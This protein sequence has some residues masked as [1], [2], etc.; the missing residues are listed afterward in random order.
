MARS[1]RPEVESLECEDARQPRLVVQCR[2]DSFRFME[3][4]E[5]ALEFAERR[6]RSPQAEPQVKPLLHDCVALREARNSCQRLSKP[7]YGLAMSGLCGGL[8]SCL[9]GVR[10][11]LIPDL[12]AHCVVRKPFDVLGNPVPIEAFGR[13]HDPRMQRPTAF[14]KETFVRHFVG[15][16][17]LECILGLREKARLMQV[18][19]GLKL[20]QALP[21]RLVRQFNKRV[22]QRR[23]NVHA[24][25]G[26]GLEQLLMHW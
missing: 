7:R 26:C 5:A 2:G 4:L 11:S 17:V 3:Q 25:D 19:G 24:D 13:L 23:W 1:C 21:Q 12:T 14:A 10:H 20:C 18:P 16:R 22:Q 8:R 6:E 9:V 15:Q